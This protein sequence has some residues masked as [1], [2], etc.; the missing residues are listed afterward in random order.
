MHDLVYWM[1]N[2][3]PVNDGMAAVNASASIARPPPL[4]SSF[5]IT[6]SMCQILQYFVYY[7]SLDSNP[8]AKF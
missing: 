1:Q 2:M 6:G 3:W 4:A 8:I 7:L 5:S